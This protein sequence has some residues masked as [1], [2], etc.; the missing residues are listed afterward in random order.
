[1]IDPLD[2]EIYDDQYP[3]TTDNKELI[4]RDQEDLQLTYKIQYEQDQL[5]SFDEFIKLASFDNKN[6]V[7][8]TSDSTLE[9]FQRSEA[10]LLHDQA[11]RIHLSINKS[12]SIKDVAIVNKTL[13]DFMYARREL[14]CNTKKELGDDDWSKPL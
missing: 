7:E 2:D 14:L 8:V 11:K 10:Q 4:K 12:R 5:D 3:T 1:M 13:I 6:I 9:T